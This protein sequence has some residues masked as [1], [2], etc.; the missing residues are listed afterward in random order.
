M[1]D[2]PS[3]R[4]EFI[5]AALQEKLNFEVINEIISSD[6]LKSAQYLCLIKLIEDFV[7]YIMTALSKHNFK[8][9]ATEMGLEEIRTMLNYKDLRSVKNWC[10]KN[11]VFIISQGNTQFVNKNEFVLALY[12]PFISKLRTKHDNW[13]TV[14]ENFLKGDLVNLL[15]DS[16]DQKKR[17]PNYKPKTKV[18]KSFLKK[19]RTL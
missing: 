16:E 13:K 4:A 8:D 15:E 11:D 9:R 2:L 6:K 7:L 5:K 19:I 10:D 12:K 14:F 17:I 3:N 1:A 18:E